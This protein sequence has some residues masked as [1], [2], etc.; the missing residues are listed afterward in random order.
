MRKFL[1]RVFSGTMEYLA[2]LFNFVVCCLKLLQLVL[3]Y[4]K[5][6]RGWQLHQG[7]DQECA[8]GIVDYLLMETLTLRSW[9]YMNLQFINFSDHRPYHNRHSGL[10]SRTHEALQ[11][12]GISTR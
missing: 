12:G 2:I 8:T 9:I 3:M 10:I 7:R 4:C 6:R 11:V 5:Y 1:G